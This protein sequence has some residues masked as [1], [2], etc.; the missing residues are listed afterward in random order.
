ML[1]R[2]RTPLI[3][4]AIAAVLV[5]P[6]I[7]LAVPIP[8]AL[9][10]VILPAGEFGSAAYTGVVVGGL[11]AAYKFCAALPDPAYRVDC[12]AERFGEIA[13][14]IP[15]GS[16][17][18]EVRSIL[19]QTSR[20]VAELARKNRD[21]SGQ[22]ARLKRPGSAETTSR[23]LTPVNPAATAQVNRQALAILESTQTLLLRSAAG[24]QSKTVQ[25]A[26]IAEAIGS[27]K[28]LLRA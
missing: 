6:T 4:T 10:T 28:V 13:K 25:Y 12:L 27:N 2:A 17:Y 26:Q 20:Q 8:G 1:S 5:S 16:D 21:P 3:A 11:G 24:S 9:Y 14:S 19:E 7:G 18:A 22:R 23:P 15:K